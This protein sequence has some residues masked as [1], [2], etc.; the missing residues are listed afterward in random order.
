MPARKTAE[1]EK[2]TF[3]FKGTIKKTKAATMKE[4]TVSD[5]TA[6]VTVDQVIEAPSDLAGYNGKDITVELSGRKKVTVGQQL[7]FNTTSWLYGD[8]IAVR[9]LSEEP[10]KASHSAML[11]AVGDPVERRRQ[12]EER[13]HFADA[14]LVVSAKVL[15][16]RLPS[17]EAPAK[18]GA[19]AA[20]AAMAARRRPVSEHDP[21]WREAVLEVA[22][23]HKGE[24]KKK[25]VVVRF[26]ASTDV[27]WYKA[28][29]FHPGQQ[30]HFM[31]TKTKVEKPPTKAVGK[32][33]KKSAAAAAAETAPVIE[34]YTALDPMDFQPYSE[35]GGI[36]TIIESESKKS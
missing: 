2:P 18:K 15:A 4:V 36:K 10:I 35:P 17:D 8:S 27:M 32:A 1:T 29:K 30:G 7:I 19:M 5:N 23:V 21:K 3:V 11:S 14:D 13:E 16:V 26:P 33:G 34:A 28:P 6:I 9:S 22:G 12:R 25:Q 20:M 24:H 31:L